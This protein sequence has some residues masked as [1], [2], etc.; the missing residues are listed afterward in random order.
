[1]GALTFTACGG[2]GGG[3]GGSGSGS[4]SASYSSSAGSS[5][6]SSSSAETSSSSSHS[7]SEASTGEDLSLQVPTLAYDDTSLHLV[8]QK[9][10]DYSNVADF[11][12]YQD[13]VKLGGAWDNNVANSQAGSYIKLFYAKDTAGFHT[14]VLFHNFK[15]TGLQPDTSY[16]FA[17]RAVYKDG[18]ES[19]DSL[20]VQ[21]WT[22]AAFT[23][24]VNVGDRGAVGDNSTLN[25]VIIQAAIDEC[26]AASTSA[27]GCKVV[28]PANLASGSE[29]KTGALFLKSNMT[30][31]IQE[32]ATL[33]GSSSADEYPL[34]KGYQIYSYFTNATDDRRP[35]SLLNALSEDHRN[36]S[37]ALA[38]H[39]GYDEQRG[40][41][42]N[43]RVTGKG[44]LDGNGWKRSSDATHELGNTLALFESSGSSTV[45]SNGVLAKN[46][47]TAATSDT[48]GTAFSNY[49][50][51]RRSSLATFRGV[52]DIYVGDLKLTNPAFHGV[53]FLESENMVFANARLETFDINNADGVEFGNSDGAIV[54]NNFVDTGD[55]CINFAAGQGKAYES[56]VEP[57]HNAWI[58]NNYLREGH[59]GVVMG[60]HTGAWIQDILAEDNVLFLTDVG[61]R[62]KST[63]ETGG[64]ARR[65]VFRDN[66]ML[67]VGT[68]NSVTLGG[69]T[70]SNNSNASPFTFTL[71]YGAGSNTFEGA[72][73]AAQFC[74]VTVRNVTVD[75]V[76]TSTGSAV[77]GLSG[78][79]AG[80]AYPET[81][82]EQIVFDTL[83]FKNVK[84]P[85][86]D[87][88]KVGS[89]RD[90]T[91][92][93][94]GTSWTI[95]NS[96]G[97]SFKS[98]TGQSDTQ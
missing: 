84:A 90:I 68:K 3:G 45:L 42:R 58:F 22:A 41:F 46:Q 95:T 56:G 30:F 72:T 38:D 94:S 69:R 87:R 79:E 88:L 81:F 75:N 27:Y 83:K 74:E 97:L 29:F 36:G 71:S 73:S 39:N 89:F 15:V 40:V 51:N 62:M 8:W 26:S 1:M 13:G 24:V 12:V 52:T 65:V 76:S 11:N 43:I 44:T 47:M 25:T 28:I 77:I 7:S 2:G 64:G 82:H 96:S 10:A 61:L 67:N 92:T 66:A 6:N 80:S 63:T 17:V 86:I 18:T 60:S 59:G 5:S 4:T 55:D 19:E 20:P 48:S 49:Y 9:P 91:F 32:G 33:R 70:F 14:K 57:M 37:S 21:D 16:R 31:E 23:N 78:S 54:F 93:D 34:S 98:V 85:S 53:M 50:S 35:P